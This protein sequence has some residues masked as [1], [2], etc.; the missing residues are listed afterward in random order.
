MNADKTVTVKLELLLFVK[1][2]EYSLQVSITK[3]MG[4][5]Q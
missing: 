1:H 5:F 3:T 2:V 4:I